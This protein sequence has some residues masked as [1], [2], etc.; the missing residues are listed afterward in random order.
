MPQGYISAIQTQIPELNI[1]T[2]AGT[3]A[4][5]KALLGEG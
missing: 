2:Y 5:Y 1:R 3:F 4:L